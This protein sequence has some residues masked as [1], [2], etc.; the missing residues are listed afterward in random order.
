MPSAMSAWPH[1]VS[2]KH[3]AVFVRACRLRHC[4]QTVFKARLPQV[5]QVPLLPLVP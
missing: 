2:P 3:V 1:L 4:A 5:T